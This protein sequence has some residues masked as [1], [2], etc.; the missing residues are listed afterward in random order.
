MRKLKSFFIGLGLGLGAGMLLVALLSPVS[1]EQVRRNW[2]DHIQAA[3]NAGREASAR[4]RAEI[5]AEISQMRQRP[6]DGP[7][8]AA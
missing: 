5:E 4:K 7:Q 2:R 1:G 3:R 8:P 6:S